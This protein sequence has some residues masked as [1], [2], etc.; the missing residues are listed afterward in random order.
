[1]IVVLILLAL[2]LSLDGGEGG[3]T[4]AARVL[5]NEESAVAQYRC[6]WTVRQ[7]PRGSHEI[8]K[9][10]EVIYLLKTYAVRNWLGSPFSMS[11]EDSGVRAI[12]VT[13]CEVRGATPF[14]DPV[15]GVLG[16]VRKDVCANIPAA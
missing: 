16:H 13:V 4:V 14:A 1:M 3:A 7:L 10:K 11:V 6:T 2:P 8:T 9:N 12:E 15:P 5:Y